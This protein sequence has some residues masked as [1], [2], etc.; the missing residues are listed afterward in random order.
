MRKILTSLLLFIV[1]IFAVCV[2]GNS[3]ETNVKEIWEERNSD[4]PYLMLE[5]Q[6]SINLKEDWTYDETE[7]IKIKI[8]NDSAK[9]LGEQ[10]IYYNKSQ[11]EINEITAF[12]TTPNGDKL[13]ATNIQDLAVYSGSAMYSDFRVKV[14]T[15]PQVTKGAIIELNIKSRTFNSILEN[16]FSD[17]LMFPVQATKYAKFTYTAPK[18]KKINFKTHNTDYKPQIT[19]D[20]DTVTYT[21]SFEETP[22]LENMEVYS[23]PYDEIYGSAVFSS[24][25][26]WS[27]IS[28]W[29]RALVKKNTIPSV[30]IDKKVKELINGK[31]KQKDK[32]KAVLEFIQD[33][34]RF[35]SLS[36]GDNML[37]P[38][39]SDEIYKNRYGDCK[40]WSLLAK[41]MLA[42]AGIKSNICLFSNE[43]SGNPEDFL[44]SPTLFTHVILEVFL[45]GKSYFVDPQT[46]GY[47]FGEHPV[48]YDGAYLFVIKDNGFRF[49]RIKELNEQI[50]ATVVDSDIFISKDGSARYEMKYKFGLEAALMTRELWTKSSE[51]VRNK[52]FEVLESGFSSLSK[53]GKVVEKSWEGMDKS[54]GPLILKLKIESPNAY[55][56]LNDMIIL[57]EVEDD[58]LAV[59]SDKERK[60]P[61]YIPNNMYD[62]SNITYHLPKEYF[63]DYIPEGYDLK[64]DFME[65]KKSFSKKA[66]E[67]KV[68]EI[69][70][71]KRAR[72]AASRLEEI[73]EFKKE[74][75]KARGKYIVLKTKVK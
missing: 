34:F 69:L 73:K 63:I 68:K 42:I 72:F 37:E 40:D 25:N 38:H 61:I 55:P 51:Q 12:V 47:D 50:N 23:P 56:V 62:E 59:F 44:P 21:F 10:E 45:D 66:Q 22:D 8:Q 26:N 24:I 29:Y 27:V 74:Y 65:I 39:K 17:R 4:S 7:Y 70:R 5:H 32:A 75:Y 15:F 36:F 67:I 54:Y 18:S 35:V 46:Q 20:K 30:E 71:I 28:D 58:Y 57:N 41:Q 14:V 6:K 64:I 1:I 43:F 3:A 53:G 16:Y 33:N 19:E 9:N 48:S 52:Y 2:N 31:R 13:P 49:D 11:D 60:Y